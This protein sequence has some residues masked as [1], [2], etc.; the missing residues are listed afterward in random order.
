MVLLAPAFDFVDLL[1]RSNPPDKL[2]AW[3][4]SGWTD[5]FHHSTGATRP[6]H[7]GLIHDARQ[8]PAIPEFLQP[9][10]IFHGTADD[11]VPISLSRAF[12]AAHPNVDLIELPSGHELLDV[13][14]QIAARAIP[15]LTA[16]R[17]AR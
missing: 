4:D 13:L 6:L 15:F 3:R 16:G 1:D 11:V 14:D 9:A 12:A 10:L 7:Y 17:P 8:Y 5:V 2:A